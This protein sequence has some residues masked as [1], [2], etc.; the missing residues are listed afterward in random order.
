VLVLLHEGL[1]S[2]AMWKEVPKQLAR[3]TGC[4]VLTY[5]R[6]GNGFSEVL[7]EP[8]AVSYMHDEALETLPDVL[9]EF[10]VRSAV[11]VGQ[12][13]GA[14][15]AL[16]YAGE[17]GA[18]LCGVAVEAPHV[19]VEDISVQSIA[20]AKVAFEST[21][22]PQRLGRYHADVSRTFYGWNDIW[23]HP[24]FRSW[25]IRECVRKIRVPI[26]AIQGVDDEYGTMAQ[27]DAIGQDARQARVD[28]L[29]LAK[30]GHAPHRDRP[31]LALPAIAAFVKSV[32]S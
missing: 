32:T 15:I 4:G 1:G 14:S 13:D 28:T 16:I 17:I 8:R 12:S 7:Q 31:D 30:C 5:S 18:R 27:L 29:A 6:Y 2:V 19:F 22:L 24:E 23:L 9:D 11:L 25:N 10:E 20:Q 3:L 21:D 26:L